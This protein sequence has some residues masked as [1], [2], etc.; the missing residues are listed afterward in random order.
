MSTVPPSSYGIQQQ[1]VAPPPF[2]SN[3]SIYSNGKAISA[4]NAQTQNKAKFGGK[5]GGAATIPVAVVPILFKDGGAGSNTTAANVTNSNKTQADLYANKQFDGCVGS[6]DPSCGQIAGK[7]RSCKKRKGRRS[8]KRSS[9]RSRSR[10]KSNKRNG[11]DRR[12][13]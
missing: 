1:T 12:S 8:R 6:S 5:R 4:N 10:S 3:G 9:K 7:R 11:R 13:K 2:G